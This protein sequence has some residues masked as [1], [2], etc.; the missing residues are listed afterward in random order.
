M[1]DLS[2]NDPAEQRANPG[3]TPRAKRFRWSFAALVGMG[4]AVGWLLRTTSYDA[5]KRAAMRP[6]HVEPSAVSDIVMTP[7]DNWTALAMAAL[8]LFGMPLL[9][10]LYLHY[11]DEHERHANLWASTNALYAAM[12]LA[13]AWHVLWMGRLVPPLNLWVVVVVS[14]LVSLVTWAWLKFRR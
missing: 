11:A 14:T 13:P 9:S 12:A 5:G 3:L 6:D 8:F 10:Y 1:T 4:F 7:L 2:K